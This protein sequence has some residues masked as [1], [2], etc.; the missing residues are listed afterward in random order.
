MLAI[1]HGIGDVSVADAGS[2]KVS[3]SLL[4]SLLTEEGRGTDARNK[5]FSRQ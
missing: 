2:T 4:A 1:K 5:Q 3:Q